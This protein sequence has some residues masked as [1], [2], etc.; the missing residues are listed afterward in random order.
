MLDFVP[1]R[2]APATVPVL[3]ALAAIFAATGGFGWYRYDLA[4]G[5]AEAARAE[6]EAARA[7]AAS[8]TVALEL[9]RTETAQLAEQLA[10][11]KEKSDDLA[12]EKRKAERKADELEDL[13]KLDPELLAKYSKVFFLNE[14]Y[15]PPKVLDVPAEYRSPEDKELTVHKQVLPFLKKMIEAAEDDGV[16]IDVASAYRSFGEQADLKGS[17]SVTY[18]TTAASK[19]SA[20]QGYSEHQL[21]TTVDLTT[22]AI[23]GGLTG[24]DKTEA[25]AWLEENAYKFGFTLSYPAGNAYYIYEPWHWR[26]V[27]ED[28]A[29][30][31]HKKGIHFYD[32]D[33]R[34][35]DSYLGEIFD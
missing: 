22:P 11:E 1:M 18:G 23:G 14:N 19:F 21:G 2:E 26:F 7:E 29:R 25:F 28:L 10:A 12:Q 27:G 30:H 35:I 32:M 34:D 5:A 13:A 8:T 6:A 20:D 24:F 16:T 33:Q 3:A 4:A 31:L 9:A 17:Y 15:T